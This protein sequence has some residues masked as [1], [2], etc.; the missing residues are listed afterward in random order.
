MTTGSREN[1]N[2]LRGQLWLGFW[3]SSTLALTCRLT[4]GSASSIEEDVHTTS[5]ISTDSYT[6]SGCDYDRCKR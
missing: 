4:K 6:F 3:S 5:P 1:L 2:Q